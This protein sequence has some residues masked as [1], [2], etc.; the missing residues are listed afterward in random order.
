M[1]V[2]LVDVMELATYTIRTFQISR[3]STAPQAFPRLTQGGVRMVCSC[4]SWTMFLN[5]FL[6][7]RVRMMPEHK[8]ARTFHFPKIGEWKVHVPE[9]VLARLNGKNIVLACSSIIRMASVRTGVKNSFQEQQEQPLCSPSECSL[10][11]VGIEN[12]FIN[13]KYSTG[14]MLLSDAA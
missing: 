10:H 13:S 6:H 9:H 5:M 14:K 4:H 12:L 7:L 1:H 3:V 2:T 8:R 11:V